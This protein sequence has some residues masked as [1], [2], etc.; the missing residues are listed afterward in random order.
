MAG[1]GIFDTK[2]GQTLKTEGR[3]KGLG[4]KLQVLGESYVG[5]IVKYANGIFYYC[6]SV[7]YDDIAPSNNDWL[8][9]EKLF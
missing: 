5:G 1:P 8:E 3:A 7:D 4:L 2:D 9:M 6:D